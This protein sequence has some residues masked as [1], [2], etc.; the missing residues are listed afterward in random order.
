MNMAT[1]HLV[2]HTPKDH[3][4][5]VF[6]SNLHGIH[7]AGAARYAHVH[8]GFPSGMG[9][10]L[11]ELAYALP[12]CVSPG[13]PLDID[14]VGRAVERFLY[15]ARMVEETDPD[16]RFFVSEVGCGL[17]GFSA[18]QVAPLFETAPANCDLPPS[19]RAIIADL[20]DERDR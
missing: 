18:E 2:F 4:I 7:G 1:E 20:I 11:G 14:G 15:V 17:A 6:G 5:F 3:R 8:L 13:V 10:G 12:T 19:F 9:E 16:V